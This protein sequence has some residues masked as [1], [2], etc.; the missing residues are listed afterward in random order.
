MDYDMEASV[1]LVVIQRQLGVSIP[2]TN[3]E[4]LLN[5]THKRRSALT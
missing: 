2:H 4:H 3:V 5:V 1:F